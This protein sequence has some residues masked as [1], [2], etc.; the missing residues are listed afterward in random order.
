MTNFHSDNL[1]ISED[2]ISGEF[3]YIRYTHGKNENNETAYPSNEGV[4]FSFCLPLSVGARCVELI[5][6]DEYADKTVMTQIIPLYSR[7]G[8]YEEYKIRIPRGKLGIGIYFFYLRINGL[9]ELYGLNSSGSVFFSKSLSKNNLFQ[10]SVYNS[11]YKTPTNRQGGIIYHLF[12]D[13]FYRKEI[14]KNRTDAVYLDSWNSEIPEYP[15]YPGAFIKNNYFYGGNLYGVIEKLDYIASLGVNTIYLSPIFEAYSNHKYDTA[16][17]MTI[18]AGFGGKVAFEKLIKEAKKRKIGIILDGVFNHTGAESIYF[19]KTGK[20]DSVGAYQSQKSPYFDWYHFEQHPDKYT[21]WWGIDILPRISPDTDSCQSYFVGEDGVIEKYAKMGVAGFRLDVADELSDSFISK[22]K[23][24]LNRYNDQSIL[25]GE[26]WE[27]ASNKIAYDVRKHYYL[28]DE[29]DGVMNYPLRTGLINYI[30]Y[31]D[32]SALSYVL[33]TVMPNMP[34][35]IRDSAMNLLG[36]HDTERILTTLG[37]K[38]SSGYTN[39]ELLNLRMSKK[40][41]EVAEARLMSAYTVLA[42]LP[43][44]PTIYYGDEAGMEG[45]S[46]PFNRRTYPWGQESKSLLKHYRAIGKIRRGNSVYQAGEFKLLHLTADLLV[47]ERS[48]NKERYI[49]VFNNS[50]KDI[51]LSFKSN[52]NDLLAGTVANKYTIKKNSALI[53]RSNNANEMRF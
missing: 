40:E 36:T 49:T 52:V 50:N 41:R 45:Y 15:E 37:G 39:S 38:S 51:G 4:S 29:L 5:V 1:R 19:N 43:G 3:G 32:T 47:F 11:K 8:S 16:D 6:L 28:G 31:H 7:K 14:I 12:V 53:F 26:V 20:Y 13:R 48:Q 33:N 46:D 22:I 17:Y 27:D 2:E 34:K 30:R 21:C 44:I 42:T 35:H 25:Y 10:V 9:T 23:A 18:D 24:V